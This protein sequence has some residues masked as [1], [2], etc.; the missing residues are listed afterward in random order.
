MAKDIDVGRFRL[1]DGG[2]DLVERE[3]GAVNPVGGRRHST[4]EHELDVV[5]AAFDLFARRPPDL[6]Y[7]I[8]QRGE[9]SV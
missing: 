4:A 3:L 5:G 7:A 2:A 8:T 6:R 1:L 9:V